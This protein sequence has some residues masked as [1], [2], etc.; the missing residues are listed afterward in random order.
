MTASA[1]AEPKA[2]ES[3]GRGRLLHGALATRNSALAV[4]AGPADV[5]EG[6]NR[7]WDELDDEGRRVWSAE[8]ARQEALAQDLP[9]VASAEQHQR[10]AAIIAAVTSKEG[11]NHCAS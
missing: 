7:R 10:I 2:N 6:T 3:R 1:I 8:I 9:L 4:L 11:A 5:A